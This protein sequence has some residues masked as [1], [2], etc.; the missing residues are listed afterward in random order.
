MM[1]N[2]DEDINISVLPPC[3]ICG[4]ESSGFHYGANTCEACKGFFRRSLQRS[5]YYTCL[6]KKSCDV[7]G[8][9]R[10]V[11]SFCRYMKCVQEGMSKKAIKTGRY[12]HERRT[13]N[14]LEVKRILQESKKEMSTSARL[15]H[16]K[17]STDQKIQT[18]VQTG[19]GDV[20]GLD[21]LI[22]TL[23]DFHDQ[24][25]LVTTRLPASYIEE[26]TRVHSEHFKLKQE[27]FGKLTTLP[28]EEYEEILR[29]T[30]IDI[31]NRKL[32]SVSHCAQVER[33]IKNWVKF[34]KKIPGFTDLNMDDQVSLLI[35]SRTEFWLLG[36]FR[37]YNC[38]LDSTIMPNGTCYH[39]EELKMLYTEEYVDLIFHLSGILQKSRLLSEEIVLLKTIC[40]TASDRASL[41]D[42]GAVERMQDLMVT[43]LQHQIRNN[44]PP[45]Q[46]AGL[47]GCAAHMLTT[48]REIGHA[49]LVHVGQHGLRKIHM[50]KDDV[51]RGILRGGV[52]SKL[53]DLL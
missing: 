45:G 12:T 1:K 18:K 2:M 42:R 32:V 29:S 23:V 52:G 48:V 14:I 27:T 28:V 22:Q 51:I 30:G 46:W 11:C 20:S 24:T 35:N 47:M 7:R 44:H 33:W 3:R 17:M 10:N 38:Q 53:E 8:Y 49:C 13:C 31:D 6:Y 39:K 34:V 5:N 19:H 4:D 43:C 36:A 15:F 37:G 25:I 41:H 40:L 16:D 50:Y 21:S 26:K 9:N